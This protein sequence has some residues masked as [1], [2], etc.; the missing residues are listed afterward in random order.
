MKIITMAL[1]ALLLAALGLSCKHEPIEIVHVQ[2]DSSGFQGVDWGTSVEAVKQR[3]E[4]RY[5]VP[6]GPITSYFAD[7]DMLGERCFTSCNFDFINNRLSRVLLHPVVG[8]AQAQYF[9][10]E[11]QK[12]FDTPH[13]DMD[14]NYVHEW[15]LGS[16]HY[17]YT[18]YSEDS[19]V[20]LKITPLH[21]EWGFEVLDV[22]FKTTETSGTH[23]RFAW[24]I[25]V[26]SWSTQSMKI[27]AELRWLDESGFVI[28]SG[29]EYDLYLGA[30]DEE[31]Y[32]GYTWIR[33]PGADKVNTIRVKVRPQ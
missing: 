4:L 12:V 6:D 33:K 29:T 24:E 14:S 15:D 7:V 30:E 22:G 28:D 31:T 3:V 17:R 10:L 16:N 2:F 1:L 8:G 25:T 27:K 13:S 26:K 20:Y 19:T 23:S 5:P 9:L 11:L 18:V 21:G 32:T